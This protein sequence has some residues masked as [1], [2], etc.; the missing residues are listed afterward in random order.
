[1]YLDVDG[2]G[3]K[4]RIDDERGHNLKAE[5]HAAMINLSVQT[6]LFEENTRAKQ[7]IVERMETYCNGGKSVLGWLKRQFKKLSN[8]I[9]RN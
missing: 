3:T 4:I 1:L 6:S 7:E 8:G 9:P 2:N 5:H